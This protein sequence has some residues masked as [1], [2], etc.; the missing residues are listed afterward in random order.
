MKKTLL[1]LPLLIANVIA[2]KSQHKQLKFVD[3]FVLEDSL[4]C[5]ETIIGG[6]SGIDFYDGDYYMVVDDSDVPRILVSQI[7]FKKDTI[8]NITF[9]D[10]IV[11]KDSMPFFRDNYFDLES[12]FVKENQI[13]LTSEGDIKKKKEPT[14]FSISKESEFIAA[15]EIPSCFK[16]NSKAKPRHNLIFEASSKSANGEGL[17]VGM[18]GALTIDG[19]VPGLEDNFCPTRITLFD[20]KTKKAIRQFAYPLDKINRPKKGKFNV[21][22]I[23]AI[24][25]YE[26]DHF[27]VVE[28]AFQ[29]GYG[30]YGNSV[31]IYKVIIDDTTKNT[32]GVE[33]LKDKESYAVTKELVFDFDTVRDKL[34]DNRID[35]IEG[36]TFGPTLSNGN[37]SLILVADDN[38]QKHGKQLNQFVVLEI[39]K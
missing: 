23:T 21:N 29:S 3:E 28:R 37:Q 7:N 36:I 19:D 18:E 16:V 38:F 9:K 12:V 11:L 17:W 39:V 2:C 30:V 24:L 20:D 14:V 6:L 31:R 34:T 32:L 26:T 25:E 27:F 5:K 13:Y 33:S 4:S 8:N 15:Y 22:G 1:L 35:N 10:V